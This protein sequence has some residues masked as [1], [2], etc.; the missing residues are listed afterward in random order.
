MQKLFVLTII[1]LGILSLGYAQTF[2]SFTEG[3][4]IGWSPRAIGMGGAFVTIEGDINGATYNPAS[5]ARLLNS[6]FL[7]AYH[8]IGLLPDSLGFGQ[9]NMTGNLLSFA[10]PDRGLWASTIYYTRIAPQEDLGI[11]YS[12][13]VLGYSM[14]KILFNNL[15]LGV[16]IKRLW[17][18]L[19]QPYMGDGIGLD[20][21]LIFKLTQNFKIGV[22]VYNLYSA[23]YWYNGEEGYHE[24]I[25]TT[26]KVGLSYQTDRLII[27]GNIDFPDLTYHFGGEYSINKNLAIRLGWNID[28]PTFGIGFKK[29]NIT[30]DYALLYSLKL[31]GFYHRVGL[32]MSF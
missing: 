8:Y 15:S 22:A 12:E 19:P 13:N 24:S 26:V 4:T 10:V 14:A 2:G 1:L 23:I 9:V 32:N 27:A 3:P 11:S 16:N 31:G 30:L 20:M 21:G 28:S 29:D 18:S 25:A 5:I 17:V 7:I 6:E